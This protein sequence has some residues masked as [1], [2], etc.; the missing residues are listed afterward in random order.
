MG[1]TEAAASFIQLRNDDDWNYYRFRPGV[2]I[3]FEQR[4]TGLYELVF[5]RKAELERWQQIFHVYPDLDR[6]P[7][8][9]LFRKHRSEPEL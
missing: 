4:T 9:D 2:G 6:F 7:T 1:T 3:G 8:K 5:V